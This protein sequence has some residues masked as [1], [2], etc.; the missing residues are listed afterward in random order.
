MKILRCFY[1]V[2]G[3]TPSLQPLR[4]ALLLS[5]HIKVEGSFVYELYW[6]SSSNQLNR[7]L[8]D[9]HKSLEIFPPLT[10]ARLANER[11]IFPAL[12]SGFFHENFFS[13]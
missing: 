7:L 6:A 8:R 4:L 1:Y 12:F 9:S 5:S 10:V 13:S 2:F 11:T 3:S